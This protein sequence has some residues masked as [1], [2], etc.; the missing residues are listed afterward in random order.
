MLELGC[1]RKV[2]AGAQNVSTKGGARGTAFRIQ[3]L[4]FRSARQTLVG[5]QAIEPADCRPKSAED[6]QYRND[7]ADVAIEK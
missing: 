5:E 4:E 1:T 7:L 3:K 6:H 2:R